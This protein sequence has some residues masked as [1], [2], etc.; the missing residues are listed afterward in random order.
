MKR[1]ESLLYIVLLLAILLDVWHDREQRL[2]VD[3]A[4]AALKSSSAALKSSNSALEQV[5]REVNDELQ[6]DHT[7][8]R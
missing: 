7:R 6:R 3:D 2:L 4:I 5:L 1:V 8:G